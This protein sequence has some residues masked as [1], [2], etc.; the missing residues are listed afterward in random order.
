MLV[1]VLRIHPPQLAGNADAPR[2]VRLKG[3]RW[4]CKQVDVSLR[5]LLLPVPSYRAHDRQALAPESRLKQLRACDPC[6]ELL[7]VALGIIAHMGGLEA[8]PQRLV[9]H[10]CAPVSADGCGVA[11]RHRLELRQDGLKDFRGQR[12]CC[13]ASGH[14]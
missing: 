2:G 3:G 13:A 11:K 6:R 12:N 5:S 9:G 14:I 1:G 10:C 8:A 7:S 4:I